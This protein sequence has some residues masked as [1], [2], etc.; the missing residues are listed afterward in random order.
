MMAANADSR[1]NLRGRCFDCVCDGYN[2]GSELKKCIRCGHP[3]GRHHNFS[4]LSIGSTLSSSSS[5]MSSVSG[6]SSW[7]LSDS[8]HPPRPKHHYGSTE[9]MIS[10]GISSIGSSSWSLSDSPHPPRPKYH[11]WST[12]SMIS[13]GISSNGSSNLS[14]FASGYQLMET[15]FDSTNIQ[16]VCACT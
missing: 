1:G 16:G 4:T 14:N 13:S 8:P 5:G 12:E 11:Y 9:S 7:S 10:S 2:G 15:G 6:S 3:P